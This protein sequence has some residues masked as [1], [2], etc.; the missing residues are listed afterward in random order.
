MSRV[1]VPEPQPGENRPPPLAASPL[2]YLR[3][4]LIDTARSFR[5]P[6]TIRKLLLGA[7]VIL[8]AVFTAAARATHGFVHLALGLGLFATYGAMGLTIGAFLAQRRDRPLSGTEFFVV[9]KLMRWL[10][11]AGVVG[12]PWLLRIAGIPYDTSL[13]MLIGFAVG[14]AVAFVG[15]IVWMLLARR[16]P[17]YVYRP[18]KFPRWTLR[19]SLMTSAVIGAAVALDPGGWVRVA[20]GFLHVI[21]GAIS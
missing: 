17:R 8:V 20:T 19:I 9:N 11:I 10:L 16:M 13:R 12:L 3:E 6:K 15:S 21:K 14:T 4:T 2:K 7:A 1:S 18:T 5:E